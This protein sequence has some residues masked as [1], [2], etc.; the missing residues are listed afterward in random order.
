MYSDEE[1]VPPLARQ[2]VVDLTDDAMLKALEKV[3]E[4]QR[5]LFGC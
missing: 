5:W 4:L 2:R 3:Q 1:N